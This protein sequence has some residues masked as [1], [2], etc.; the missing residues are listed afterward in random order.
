MADSF[1]IRRSVD[2]F[3]KDR[4]SREGGQGRG[5]QKAG[6]VFQIG[7]GMRLSIVDSLN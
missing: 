7:P 6:R 5:I 4:S 3:I 2:L 1:L